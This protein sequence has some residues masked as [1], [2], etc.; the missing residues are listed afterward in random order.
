MGAMAAR[1]GE[2][3]FLDLIRRHVQRVGTQKQVAAALGVSPSF[4]NDILKERR[5]ITSRLAEQFGYRRT[6]VFE[7]TEP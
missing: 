6:V 5:E 7:K 1:L 4:L 3:Q 2:G